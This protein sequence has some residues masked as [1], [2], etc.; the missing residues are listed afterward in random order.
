MLPGPLLSPSL[1]LAS[2]HVLLLAHAAGGVFVSSI[3][4]LGLWSALAP[5]ALTANHGNVITLPACLL[6]NAS[7]HSRLE[8]LQG[9]DGELFLEKHNRP[10]S[11]LAHMKL[12]WLNCSYS[13]ESERDLFNSSPSGKS[14]LRVNKSSLFPCIILPYRFTAPFPPGLFLSQ[15]L[16]WVLIGL[17]HREFIPITQGRQ[18]GR[19]CDLLGRAADWESGFLEAVPRSAIDLGRG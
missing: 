17:V 6:P 15:D 18:T 4:E 19:Q 10:K 3:P 2:T 16:H 11:V 1:T 5:W 8:A 7:M 9:G 12:Q 13:G 14:A